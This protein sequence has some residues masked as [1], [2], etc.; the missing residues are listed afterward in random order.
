[1]KIAFIS[2]I[3]GNAV[4]LEAVLDD[5]KSKGVDKIIVLGDISF[6]GPQ[7]KRALELVRELDT[8]V[9]KGNADEWLVRG[10]SRGEVPDARLEK[11]KA[12]QEWASARLSTDDIDYLKDLPEDITCK[13]TDDFKIHAFHATPDS[14][15]EPVKPDDGDDILESKL[16]KDT[17]ADI[18]LYGHIHLPYV[19]FINGKCIANLGSVG[20]P[21]D[22]N[23]AASYLIVEGEN[24]R[25]S[26]QTQR[27]PYDVQKVI[28]QLNE[29]DYPNLDIVTQMIKK[30][31]AV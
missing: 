18:F 25:F 10:I 29:V 26:V 28:Q 11:M 5:I 1:M 22:G 27:V 15:F 9:I 19:R 4:A 24:E 7:P 8:D 13:L 20:L 6:R 21:F 12:E 30:G 31:V 3:H 14:L 23:T 17:S 16:I 2:D